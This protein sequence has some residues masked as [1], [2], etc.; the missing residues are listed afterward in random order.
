MSLGYRQASSS[1]RPVSLLLSVVR[2][3]LCNRQTSPLRESVW[4]QRLS[5]ESV[6]QVVRSLMSRHWQ[7]LIDSLN[8]NS[9]QVSRHSKLASHYLP[10]NSK[11]SN[12]GWTLRPRKINWLQRSPPVRV[13]RRMRSLL[14]WIFRGSSFWRMRQSTLRRFP[15]RRAFQLRSWLTALLYLP[16]ILHL[17]RSWQV[18]KSPMRPH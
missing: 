9:R 13:L 10:V 1:S 17:K 12:R 16:L 18:I 11:Q 7:R 15:H 3:A 2:R 8:L 4:P 5:P 6:L 14:E